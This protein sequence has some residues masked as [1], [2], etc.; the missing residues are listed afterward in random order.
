MLRQEILNLS[1]SNDLQLVY[2]RNDFLERFV[3]LEDLLDT[4]ANVIVLRPDN[5][6]VHDMPGRFEGVHSGVN[7]TFSNRS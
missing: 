5:D 3:V 6:G 7:S 4:S 1:G 2:L